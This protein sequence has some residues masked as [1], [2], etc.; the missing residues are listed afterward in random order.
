MVEVTEEAG[1][2][3]SIVSPGVNVMVA[4][5]VSIPINARSV[6]WHPLL[7]SLTTILYSPT[8]SAWIVRPLI[9]PI[10][11]PSGDVQLYVTLTPV[12]ELPPIVK[13]RS[14]QVSV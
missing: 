2:L 13:T 1:V 3:Q 9:G 7:V 12:V 10:I 11:R 6:A 14:L 5:A 8:A 4:T